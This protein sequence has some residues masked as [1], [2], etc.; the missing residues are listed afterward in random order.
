MATL[1]AHQLDTV[2][3]KNT[4]FVSIE[5]HKRLVLNS[6]SFLLEGEMPKNEPEVS[7][8]VVSIFGFSLNAFV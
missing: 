3:L 5:T 8:E 7:Q 2:F 6:G 4:C 1:R